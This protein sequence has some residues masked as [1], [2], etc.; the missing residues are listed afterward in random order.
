MEPAGSVLQKIFRDLLARAPASEAPML[1]WPAV[2]GAAVAARTR[3]FQF[4]E[5]TLLVKVPDRAWKTQLSELAPR[6]VAALAGMPGE[7]VKRIEFIIAG[8]QDRSR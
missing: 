5:G 1:A 8:P 6:Y 3:A 4:A 7:Q 2:C